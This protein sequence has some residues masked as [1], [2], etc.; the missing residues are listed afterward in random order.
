[1]TIHINRSYFS[2]EE[3]DAGSCQ[4]LVESVSGEALNWFSRLE[5]NSIDGYKALTSAFLQ[6]HQCFMCTPASNADLWR[7]YQK[8]KESLRTFMERFK[9]VMSQLA[10]SD[11]SAIGAL[12]NALARDTRFKDD[13]TI[14]PVTSLGEVLARAN[15]YIQVDED[16]DKRNPDQPAADYARD[17]KGR[18]ATTFAIDGKEQQQNKPWNKYYR[19][20]D[21][22]G[23]KGKRPYCKF[24]RFNGHST[25]E[26]KTLQM[27]LLHKYKRGDVDIERERRKVN[28]HKDNQ[29]C[30]GDEQ[31]HDRQREEEAVAQNDRAWEIVRLPPPPKRNHDAEER[32]EPPAPRRRIHMIMGGL[33]TS[34]D[35]VRSI[36]AYCRET[37][38]KRNMPSHSN[39]FKT[40]SDPITF[41]EEDA[42]NAS[43]NNNPLVVEMVIGESSVTRILI[44]TRSSVNIIFKDVLIQMEIDLRNTAHETQ[45]LTGFSGDTIRT[46]GTITLPIYVGGTMHC[47]NFGI[48]DNPIVYNVILGTPWLHKMLVV[49]STYHQCVKFPNAYGIYTL[50]GDPLMVRTCF[51]IEKKMRNARSFIKSESA[52]PRDPCIP[53][54][55]EFVIQVNI[56]LSNSKRCVG[57]GAE[58]PIALRDELVQVLT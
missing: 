47:F 2:P 40:S 10:I 46:V 6:H 27:L 30:L 12:K 50:R 9:G 34:R 45:P 16:K 19:E 39:M 35:S 31:Q 1:M 51:I 25:E 54:P 5:A 42:H 18:K 4:L 49:A 38:T 56:D 28:T 33:S 15:R 3:A 53:P 11:A 26:C 57:I 52:P 41:T 36:Q 55:K 13:L 22:P 37:E 20:S 44:D 32:D 7:M 48:L 58:L 17:E 8:R 14:L 24:H 43:P 23:Y 29:Y 21:N